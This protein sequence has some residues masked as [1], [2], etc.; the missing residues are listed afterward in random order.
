[1]TDPSFGNP[2]LNVNGSIR[3]EDNGPRSVIDLSVLCDDE[4]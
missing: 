1:V 3:M 4:D 2:H